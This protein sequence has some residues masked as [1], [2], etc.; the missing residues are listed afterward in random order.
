MTF[1][2]NAW[3]NVLGGIGAGLFFLICY[4]VVQWFL[5]ATDLK[6]RYNWRYDHNGGDVTY[7]PFFDIRNCS[8]SKSYRL[9][10]IAYTRNGQMHWCDND[11][12]MGVVIEP[13]SMNSVAGAP[14]KNIVDTASAFGL[15][16]TIRDQSERS[17]W[18][19]GE[20]PGQQGKSG[21]RR[22]A[23]MLRARL[24]KLLIPL[25]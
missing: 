14:V 25:E 22:A 23:F 15:E 20:G 8:R 19:R 5:R 3:S 10:N 16:V 13:G 17:F 18:L 24:E 9:A 21:I 12:I 1:W 4:I 7:R 11:S 2:Q 6:I